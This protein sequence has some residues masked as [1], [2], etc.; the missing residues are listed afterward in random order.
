MPRLSICVPTYNRANHLK[1]LLLTI[2]DN[3]TPLDY[4]LI[5]QDNASTDDTAQVFYMVAQ[6]RANW[7]Y[8]RNLVNKGG[9]A[10]VRLCTESSL[11][12]FVYIVG[13]DDRLVPRAF[14][15]ILRITD[16]CIEANAV[17]AF[18]CSRLPERFREPQPF[19]EGVEWLRHMGINWP[20]FI[21]SVIW[22]QRFWLEY[23]Y[24][25]YPPQLSLPQL[26]CFISACLERTV[27]GFTGDLVEI[28]AAENTGLPSYWFYPRHALVD[29]FEYPMLYARVLQESRS[30]MITR[31]F[32]HLR[33]LAKLR[34]IPEK[35]LFLRYNEQYYHPEINDF[36]KVHGRC[37]Y[38]PLMMAFLLFVLK[39]K[40]G[41]RLA[42]KYY[43]GCPKILTTA[44]L[45]DRF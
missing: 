17:A 27:V 2:R 31:I 6:G 9:F 42:E 34:W 14:G 18:A 35:T 30:K 45:Y 15:D 11:G 39:T 8:H 28:G 29:C 7:R 44:Q 22:Q 38:W 3:A 19:S 32:I 23:P 24:W 40:L 5:V 43:S 41:K 10:N 21:S 25:D 36:R 12:D 26:D 33:R 13:D 16:A 1:Q 20:A 37:L 4:E